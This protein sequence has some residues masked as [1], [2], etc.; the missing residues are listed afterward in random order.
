M[1]GQRQMA[2]FCRDPKA[3]CLFE[4]IFSGDNRTGQFKSLDIIDILSS[5]PEAWTTLQANGTPELQTQS[6]V[7]TG[8]SSCLKNLQSSPSS[9]WLVL[10]ARGASQLCSN[11]M[12]KPFLEILSQMLGA[13]S[14]SMSFQVFCPF[15]LSKLS[16]N[17]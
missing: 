7:R 1:Q 2:R 16:T 4:V 12:T 13:P 8:V 17:A 6:V 9:V 10:F 14:N 15:L 3:F 11:R 5:H